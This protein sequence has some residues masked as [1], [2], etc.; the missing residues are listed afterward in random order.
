MQNVLK[1]V[2]E[3]LK[4]ATPAVNHPDA[5]VLTAFSERA[6]PELERAIVL[7]HL[8]R[9]GDCRDIVALSLPETEAVEAA[10]VPA[11]GPWFAWPTLR[12]AFVAAGVVAIASLG[13]VQL[14]H[15][16]VTQLASKRSVNREAVSVSLEA[17]NQN[18]S[19]PMASS[20]AETKQTK[21]KKSQVPAL[22][23]KDSG[24]VSGRAAAASNEL[25]RAEEPSL[26][27]PPGSRGAVGGVVAGQLSNGPKMPEQWQQRQNAFGL[28]ANAAPAPPTAK[29]KVDAYTSSNMLTTEARQ[30]AQVPSAAPAINTAAENLDAHV[31]EQPS[32]PQPESDAVGKAKQPVK[33]EAQGAAAAQETMVAAT[34]RDISAGRNDGANVRNSNQLNTSPSSTFRWIV[35]SDGGLER[36]V[37]RGNSWQGVDVNA[38]NSASSMS[39]KLAAK[40]ARAKDKSDTKKEAA[41]TPVFRAVAAMGTEVWAGGS[42]GALFH[43]SDG[44]NHW[45]RVVP[46]FAGS[47]LTGDVVT[48]EFSDPQHG[49][50]TT[51]TPEVWTTTD[52]G[53]TWQKQ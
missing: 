2:R 24:N 20:P 35:N 49:K 33:V 7:E 43:S 3:R 34:P 16:E 47:T 8:A 42:T 19:L 51:S 48:L 38:Q 36:S 23:L 28:Q 37:D 40:A 17:K 45:T 53:Q 14:Q 50:I 25:M 1:I 29:Q 32:A 31:Q 9:C 12:W 5:N 39:S 13:V 6:L 15:R 30:S 21:E 11:R 10:T 22:A 18:T 46:L 44:G 52:A 41:A 4:A 27:K 26:Q